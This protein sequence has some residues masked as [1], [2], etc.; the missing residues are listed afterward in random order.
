MTSRSWVLVACAVCAAA[1]SD[2]TETSSSTAEPASVPQDEPAERSTVATGPAAEEN[3]EGSEGD[4][5]AELCPSIVLDE[6]PPLRVRAAPNGTAEV[7]GELVN[8]SLVE[9]TRTVRGWARIEAP[10]AGWVYRRPL[11]DTCDNTAAA[12]ALVLGSR[13]YVLLESWRE[14]SDVRGPVLEG[15]VGVF[16]AME[17][18]M[19]RSQPLPPT[20]VTLLSA[21]GACAGF[22]D[23]RVEIGA[24][25]P[26]FGHAA[27]ALV[28]HRCPLLQAEHFGEEER[29][30][31]AVAVFGRHPDARLEDW[32]STEASVSD[33]Q[34]QVLASRDDARDTTPEARQ[35]GS[36]LFWVQSE[37]QA[38]LFHRDTLLAPLAVA[39]P[40]RHVVSNGRHLVAVGRSGFHSYG[41]FMIPRRPL[42]G[43]VRTVHY[44]NATCGAF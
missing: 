38:W 40:P 6:S 1:C 15:G 35:L 44:P 42:P 24:H 17:F 8:G 13:T 43:N 30:P 4:R 9:V 34:R 2:G 37:L 23:E 36:D 21:L 28:V 31:F 16:G 32:P 26:E 7:V 29:A 27:F 22:G 20:P 33:G 3:P 41:L 11:Y 12:P 18:R 19:R 39:D 5:H 25:C 10:H 14:V